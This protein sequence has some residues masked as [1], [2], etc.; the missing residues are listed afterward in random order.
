MKK[1]F[2]TLALLAWAVHAEDR[3][4]L[5]SPMGAPPVA[6]S[7]PVQSP[8]TWHER[9]ASATVRSGDP[10][11]L[12]RSLIAWTEAH[13]GWFNSLDEYSLS[14][15]LPNDQLS[16]LLDTLGAFGEVRDKNTSI[17]DR[18]LE[19]S[20]LLTQIKTRRQ[21]LDQYF[22]MVKS[23]S[24]ER[25]QAVEREVV[26]LTA[27]IERLEGRRRFLESQLS[28]S[29]VTLFFQLRERELPPP[30]GKSPFPW[31]DR[32]NLLDLKEAF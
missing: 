21:L 1:T 18:A 23:S 32:L 20:E 22:S 7:V 12:A 30:D 3:S 19:M 5:P 15:R 29:S 26:D 14:L 16:L 13:G 27:D 2:M 8:S 4:I 10:E 11:S 17:E 6:S 28:Y 25:L 31:L 9:H 24:Q